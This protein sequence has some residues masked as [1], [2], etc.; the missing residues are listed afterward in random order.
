MSEQ[1]TNFR[2]SD[3][4]EFHEKQKLAYSY[5]GKKRYIYYGGARG[6]GK[7]HWALGVAVRVAFRYPGIKITIIRS[8]ARELREEIIKRLLDK[9]PSEMYRYN[10][11]EKVMYIKNGVNGKQGS[12][13]SFISMQDGMDVTKEQGIER[14]M[15]IV[16]EANNIKEE[17]LQ[18]LP[19]SLRNTTIPNWMP[20]IIYT[21]NPGGISDSYFRKFF[22]EPSVLNKYTGWTKEQLAYKDSYVFINATVDDNPVLLEKNP[23]YVEFLDSLP[24]DVRRAW[25]HGDFFVFSGRFFSEFRE[26]RHVV[27]DFEPPA[28]WV[29][30]RAIDLGQGSHPSVCLWMTQEPKSGVVYVYRELGHIGSP[31]DFVADIR[32]MSPRHETY[33]EDFADPRMF[34]KRNDVYDDSDRFFKAG[35]MIKEAYN[36]RQIG[37]RS[38]KQWLYCDD[39]RPPMLRITES[40]YGLRRT[41]PIMRYKNDMSFD[42]NT[43]D[44]DDYVDALRYG[45]V[46]IEYGYIYGG[47]GNYVPG[48]A[49]IEEEFLRSSLSPAGH[50]IKSA[51]HTRDNKGRTSVTEYLTPY[52]EGE[53]NT[54]DFG[55]TSVYSIF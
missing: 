20:C 34:A 42:L 6:G 21:G 53:F 48:A 45:L 55:I 32:K 31:H 13:I 27:P 49:Y 36:G 51:A 17:I 16:D 10:K 35:I 54:K 4:Y 15:Y 40:C 19:G 28:E 26:D 11:T 8:T 38:V 7:T 1:V 44:E 23:E 37:W 24:P 50:A 47:V 12:M 29:K 5:I 2:I 30:W 22:V 43:K 46:H 25:R 9:V 3:M 14:Q 18:K 33:L 39:S 41:I 52:G